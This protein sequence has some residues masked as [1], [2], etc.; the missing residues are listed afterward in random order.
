TAG[1]HQ[2]AYLEVEEYGANLEYF[3]A[4]AAE[5]VYL[6]PATRTPFV[7]MA[8]EYLFLGGLWEK[9]GV[10]VEVE[11]V[12][13]YKSAAEIYA[14]KEMSEPHRVMANALL[15]SI[16]QNFVRAVAEARGLGP[17]EVSAAID[18]APVVPAEMKERKLIDGIAFL[19]EVI[20]MQGKRPVIKGREYAAVRPASVGINPEATF[21]L[22]YGSGAV[23]TGD[24]G[25]DA[26]G[27]PQLA[28]ETVSRA[29]HD[30]A[31]DPNIR[32]IIFRVDSP[33]GSPLAADLVWRA[34]QQARAKGKPVVASF[35]DVAASG[36]Y[37]AACGVDAIVAEPTTLTGSIGVFV[38]RPIVGGLLDKLG[39]GVASLTRG[40]HADLLLSTQ[41]LKPDTRALLQTEV[42]AV[43]DLFVSRVAEG[44]KLSAARV[45]EIG[46]GRVWT[47]AQARE[48]G[49]VDELG[50]LHAA[51]TKAKEKAGLR[52]E[53]DVMLVVFPAPEPLAVQIRQAL[54]GS[55]VHAVESDPLLPQLPASLRR[56][57]GWLTSVPSGSPVLLPPVA[58]EIR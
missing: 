8:A 32:A 29:F 58:V 2:I 41:P 22:I 16:S 45:D 19:D 3:I 54:E 34:T 35:S 12:G 51:V 27:S 24:A 5:R 10:Q 17:E 55:A 7:G 37:Y 21:A 48:V 31:E 9:F 38:L 43:Y 53:A 14:A 28:A 26:R 42:R 47:G 56:V 33:G 39:I 50:G 23:V 1:R 57:V 25:S 46:R 40:A 49:L 6:S 15:D 36:G 20:E 44:R 13:E 18:A 52:P 4:S 30:A 11:R